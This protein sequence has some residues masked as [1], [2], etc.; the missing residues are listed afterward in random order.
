MAWRHRID[1]I[2]LTRAREMRQPQTPAEATLWNALKNQKTGYKFRR[3]HPI[4]RF[5]TDFYCAKARLLIEVDG[6]SHMQPEQVDYDAVRTEYLEELGY[7]VIRFT[8]DDVRFNLNA[9]IS[10][11]LKI[12]ESRILYLR[13]REPDSISPSPQPAPAGEREK[14]LL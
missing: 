6:A 8:N 14:D 2:I 11:I 7:Q 9:V 4:S 10:E 1:P 5:I 13:N 12:I 3:Q